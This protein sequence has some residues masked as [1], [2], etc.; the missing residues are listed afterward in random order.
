[1]AS[2]S[3]P[4]ASAT[5]QKR[6]VKRNPDMTSPHASYFDEKDMFMKRGHVESLPECINERPLDE[7]CLFLYCYK[8]ECPQDAPRRVPIRVRIYSM[9]LGMFL[10]RLYA[11]N[12]H[13]KEKRDFIGRNSGP[14]TVDRTQRCDTAQ[15][16]GTGYRFSDRSIDRRLR[17]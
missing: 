16:E 8:V 13:G 7:M 11:L 12:L 10:G 17:G 14:K 15:F 9:A 4:M 6:E 2:R 3:L 1:M 5:A